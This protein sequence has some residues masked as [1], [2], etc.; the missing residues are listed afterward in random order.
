MER[1]LAGADTCSSL[2]SGEAGTCSIAEAESSFSAGG[3]VFTDRSSGDVFADRR[4]AGTS[5][6][7]RGGEQP[8]G[9]E[10]GRC[11]HRQEERNPG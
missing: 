5:S 7:T 9:P 11:L 8:H 3:D 2:S 6:Q 1:V 4:R 10:D